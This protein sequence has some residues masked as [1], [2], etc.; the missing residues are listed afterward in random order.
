MA[1]KFFSA[2]P[3]SSEELIRISPDLY[4][5]LPASSQMVFMASSLV[6]TILTID[7]LSSSFL[8]DTSF[9]LGQNTRNFNSFIGFKILDQCHHSVL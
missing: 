3:F 4:V 7:T 8:F 6:L 1:F 9:S 2:C 5:G